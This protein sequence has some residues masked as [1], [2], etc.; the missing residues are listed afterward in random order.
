MT[1]ITSSNEVSIPAIFRVL[2]YLRFH[3]MPIKVSLFVD[4]D[5][6]S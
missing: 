6:H 4:H 5:L 1:S 3:A 2:E